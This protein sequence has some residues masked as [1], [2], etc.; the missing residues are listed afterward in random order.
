MSDFNIE[1]EI[2]ISLD[3]FT[4]EQTVALMGQLADV[5]GVIGRSDFGRAQLTFTLDDDD[6]FAPESGW[7]FATASH[8]GLLYVQTLESSGFLPAALV[9][10]R[11]LPTADFDRMGKLEILPVFD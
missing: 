11:V 9:S 5:H 4:D 7:T 8:W 1:A 2:S 3:H 10:F 6:T